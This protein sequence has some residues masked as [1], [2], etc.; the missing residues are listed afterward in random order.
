VFILAKVL[1]AI[2]CVDVLFALYIG[3][4]QPQGMGREFQITGIGILVFVLG[5][6]IERF[7]GEQS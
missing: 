4:T 3:M 7:S 6:L 2:G 1:E 5:Y